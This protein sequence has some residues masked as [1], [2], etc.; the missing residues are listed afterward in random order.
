MFL[1][2][3]SL[4]PQVFNN[5]TAHHLP[6]IEEL[7]MQRPDHVRIATIFA[8]MLSFTATAHAVVQVEQVVYR[9]ASSAI[10]PTSNAVKDF[11]GG[12]L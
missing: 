3:N 4:V 11:L 12:I 10:A 1:D 5:W 8:A 7:S 6:Q 2:R 9:T